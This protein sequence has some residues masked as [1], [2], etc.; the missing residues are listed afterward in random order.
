VSKASTISSILLRRS[1]NPHRERPHGE[2]HRF[3]K[4]PLSIEAKTAGIRRKSTEKIAE[5]TKQFH[6]LLVTAR[7]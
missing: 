2:E 7:R 4:L 5:L 3:R 6:T 1:P